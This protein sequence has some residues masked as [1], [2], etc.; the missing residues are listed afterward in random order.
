MQFESLCFAESKMLSGRKKKSKMFPVQKMTPHSRQYF[1]SLLLSRSI[2]TSLLGH[3]L[4]RTTDPILLSVLANYVR[5]I[6]GHPPGVPPGV[7]N[8][9]YIY[10]HKFDPHLR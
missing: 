9:G 1:V 3:R 8:A 7:L 2:V 10:V 4:F 5:N 6:A